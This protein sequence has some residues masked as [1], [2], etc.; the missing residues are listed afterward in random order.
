MA[1]KRKLVAVIAVA[2]L[3]AVCVV[4]SVMDYSFGDAL[5][6]VAH[7]G[8][9]LTWG[10][11]SVRFAP[12]IYKEPTVELNIG[13]TPPKD[14]LTLYCSYTI[15]DPNNAT[16][17]SGLMLHFPFV[18]SRYELYKTLTGLADGNYR[19]QINAYQTNGTVLT[20]VNDTF[21]VDRSF[22]EPK[23]T[24]ISPQNQTYHTT[25]IDINYSTNAPIVWA[26]Y[27]LDNTPQLNWV[28]FYGNTTL[29]F[30][31]GQHTLQIYVQTE[32][33]RHIARAYETCTF[34]F[35]IEP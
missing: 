26:Y 29:G 32:A 30:P 20:P 14:T 1:L 6:D 23:L 33:N 5:A 28:L 25:Q 15:T 4:G 11:N 9:V 16:L 10:E 21:T 7:S 13:Y 27:N 8:S 19:L 34:Y 2:V 22:T 3:L 31:P 35:T 18:S 12:Y 17:D 24:P